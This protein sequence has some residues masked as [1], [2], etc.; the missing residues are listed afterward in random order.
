MS[1]VLRPVT[2]APIFIH[3]GRRNSAL[4]REILNTMS[5]PGSGKSVSPLEYHLKRASPPSPKPL[6]GPSFGPV[7]K[8]SRDIDNSKTTL[9]ISRFPFTSGFEKLYQHRGK[10][11]S[12]HF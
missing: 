12:G 8:P 9:L 6:S 5:V 4:A 10:R 1:K 2:D 7:I 11:L 3:D